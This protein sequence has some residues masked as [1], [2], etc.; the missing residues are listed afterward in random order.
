VWRALLLAAR[1]VRHELERRAAAVPQVAMQILPCRYASGACDKSARTMSLYRCCLLGQLCMLAGVAEAAHS[2]LCACSMCDE[3]SACSLHCACKAD[4]PRLMLQGGCSTLR[5]T[6]RHHPGRQQAGAPRPARQRL[7]SSASPPHLQRRRHA[8]GVYALQWT[9]ATG[10]GP[11]NGPRLLQAAPGLKFVAYGMSLQS[12]APAPVCCNSV[13]CTTGR[14]LAAVAWDRGRIAAMG[15]SSAHE[16]L[17]LQDSG[18]VCLVHIA[19][20]L[21]RPL[22]AAAVLRAWVLLPLQEPLVLQAMSRCP[23][24]QRTGSKLFPG[25]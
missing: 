6:H 1:A 22:T 18:E 10:Q 19:A 3:V 24:N 12:L 17:A 13:G 2:C 14:P 16:L 20:I 8:A 23:L 5:R 15:W 11:S 25:P 4:S 9:P 7:N 21:H